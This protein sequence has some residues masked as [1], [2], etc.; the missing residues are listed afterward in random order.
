MKFA[1]EEELAGHHRATV[2]GAIEG[3]LAGLAISV[4][5]S[6]YLH[7]RWA[8][9]RKLPIQLKALGVVMIVAPLY[10]VQAERRGYEFDRSTWTGAGMNELQREEAEENKKW[11]ALGTKDK[12]RQWATQNQYKVIMG[13]WAVSMAAAGLLVWRDKHQSPAQKI[14][15]ARMWA[16]GLTIGILIAAGVMTHAQRQEAAQHRAPVDHSWANMVEEFQHEEREAAKLRLPKALPS[17]A[18]HSA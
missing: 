3:T 9:Y 7:R 5:G 11:S 13:S 4:P 17:P 18:S 14:V 16:Q 2:R 15:Q 10:A 12:I 1:T 8:S 6:Y